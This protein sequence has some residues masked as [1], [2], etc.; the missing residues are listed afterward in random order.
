MPPVGG[1]GNVGSRAS[2][3]D[4]RPARPVGRTFPGPNDAALPAVRVLKRRRQRRADL[5]RLRIQTDDPRLVHVEDGDGDVDGVVDAGIGLAGGVLAVANADGHLVTC[6]LLVVQ[7]ALQRDPAAASVDGERVGSAQGVGQTVIVR[8]AG[9]NRL[10]DH[11]ADGG[12]LSHLAVRH[13]GG[14]LRPE[15]QRGQVNRELGVLLDG[16][17]VIRHVC[18]LAEQGFV[19]G[20][21]MRGQV[22]GRIAPAC[23]AVVDVPGR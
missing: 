7:R 19:P 21:T 12:V 15:I 9:D 13:V 20:Q 3:C 11:S 1:G 6:A 5:R 2:A 23:A 10:A 14:E 22:D 4:R 18:K 16:F 8:G 17:E